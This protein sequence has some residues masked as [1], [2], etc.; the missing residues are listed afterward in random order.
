MSANH[1]LPDFVKLPYV[2]QHDGM[3]YR[4][5]TFSFTCPD[6]RIFGSY[7]YALDH[8]DAKQLCEAIK[9]TI[10]L[11]GQIK[12]SIDVDASTLIFEEK[13]RTH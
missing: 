1:A 13:P 9:K 3:D 10:H 2:I 12:L 11:D 7:F 8:Q 6:G 4:L 5:F